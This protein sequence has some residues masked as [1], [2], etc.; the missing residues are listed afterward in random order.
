LSAAAAML[1]AIAQLMLI[2]AVMPLYTCHYAVASACSMLPTKNGAGLPIKNQ[3]H[4]TFEHTMNFSA[5][6]KLTINI[7]T[8]S[9]FSGNTTN[10]GGQSPSAKGL[11][12]IGQPIPPKF[13]MGR[14]F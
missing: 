8:G 1:A 5:D 6:S 2:Q 14:K 12:Q 7:K 4:Q 11:F 10:F 13:Q 3:L 9:F